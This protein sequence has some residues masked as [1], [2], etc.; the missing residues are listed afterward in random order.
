MTW[1]EVA[2]KEGRLF[3][4]RKD[5]WCALINMTDGS[6]PRATCVSEVP[7]CSTVKEKAFSA[8]TSMTKLERVQLVEAAIRRISNY[9]E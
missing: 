2:A 9:V 4:Q 6:C 7:Q 5:T 1:D 3:C 8:P